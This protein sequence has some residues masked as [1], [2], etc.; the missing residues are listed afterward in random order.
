MVGPK[1]QSTNVEVLINGEFQKTIQITKQLNNSILIDIPVKFRRD[2][3]LV[4]EFKYLN[5]TSPKSAGY[6]NEDD[7]LLTL[8]IESAQIIR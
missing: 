7:R 8:G 4:V 6:G 5:P 3:Y 2:K 1:H